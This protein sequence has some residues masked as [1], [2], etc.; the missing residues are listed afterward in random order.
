MSVDQPLEPPL[1]PVEEEIE[2]EYERARQALA[3]ELWM[4]GVI[5][6]PHLD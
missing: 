2:R 4:L 6:E 5:D 3:F 1:L